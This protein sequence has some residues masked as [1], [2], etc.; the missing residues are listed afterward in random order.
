MSPSPAFLCRR[1]GFTLVEM[2]V[3]IAIAGIVASMIAVFIRSPVQAYFDTERRARLTEAA[4]TA[5]RRVARD[6]RTA[7]PNSVRV[8]AVGGSTFLEFIPTVGG[9]R[10]RNY[11]TAA[12]AGNP[13]DFNLADA[14]FD[15]VGPVPVYA[16]GNSAVVYN[17]GPGTIADAYAGNNRAQL[18]SNNAALPGAEIALSTDAAPHTVTLAA[19]TQFPAASP[20]SLF[21]VVTTPVT[22]ECTPNAAVPAAGTLLRYEGYAFTAGQPTPPAGA[23][24]TVVAGVSACTIAY[25]PVPLRVRTAL[26]TLSLTLADAGEAITVV[27]QMHVHN[28]P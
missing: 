9:G 18:T 6:V 2:V 5:L 3:V 28:T 10:Y 4:D 23:A 24:R 8:T 21:Q 15:V 1:R 26:I 17:L 20:S 27:H 19:A 7:L 14:A 11:P 25:D 16:A 13:L 22:Y 12:G